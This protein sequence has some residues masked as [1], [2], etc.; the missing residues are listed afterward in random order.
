MSDYFDEGWQR[1]EWMKNT[2]FERNLEQL[3]IVSL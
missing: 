3:E 1:F 2:A